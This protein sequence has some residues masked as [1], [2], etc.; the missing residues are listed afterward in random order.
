MPC[1]DFAGQET[2]LGSFTGVVTGVV[3]LG[4]GG[5]PTNANACYTATLTASNGD[6]VYVFLITYVTGVDSSTGLNTYVEA[7]N[8]VGG[9][10][11]FANA[12]GT[13]A[14]FGEVNA[15][16]SSYYASVSGTI[17]R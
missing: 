1:L 8:V 16:T 5:C 6:Q 12:T 2:H 3:P 17:T 11:R 4:T 7:I 14:G 9:T 13:G 10:G 15:N